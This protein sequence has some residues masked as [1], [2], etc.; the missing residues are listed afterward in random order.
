MTDTVPS[1]TE[2]LASEKLTAPAC[3]TC[4]KPTKLQSALVPQAPGK[5][6]ALSRCAQHGVMFVKVRFSQLPDGQKGMHLSV[7]PANHQN[8]AYVHTKEL[9]YQ[10]KKKRG[11][12]DQVDIEDLTEA[13]SSNMP[14]EDA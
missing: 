5:Y 3:P 10:L 12:Y 14:F 7:L 2:A 13:F 8:R 6:V 9:Q 11:D 1:V 4:Q